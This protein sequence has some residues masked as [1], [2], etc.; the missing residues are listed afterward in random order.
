MGVEESGPL[1]TPSSHP[2]KPQQSCAYKEGTVALCKMALML[3]SSGA[4][5]GKIHKI[6]LGGVEK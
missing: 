4:L 2:P 3:T 1:P 6:H 5:Y